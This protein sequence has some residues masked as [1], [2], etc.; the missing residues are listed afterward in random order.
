MKKGLMM[1]GI[2]TMMLASCTN[3]DVLNVS[4]SRAIGFNGTGIDNI[5]KAGDIT[6]SNFAHFYVYGGYGETAIFDKTEVSYNDGK[7]GYTPTKY[8]ANGTWKFAGY[9]GGNGV[10][11]TWSYAN[12]LTLEVNSNASHQSDVVYAASLDITVEDATTYNTPVALTFKHLLSKIQFKF[13]KDAQSLGGV[14]V[15]L[16]NFTVSG[17]TTN[18]K[19]E[20]G[21]QKA[22]TSAETGSYS[23]FSSAEE[24]VA[25]TGL[26]TDAFYVIPQTVGTFTITAN[27]V[28]T[29]A[30]GTEVH[31]GQIK[32]TVPTT[33]ITAW[34]AQNYY[35]YTATVA[36]SNIKDPENPDQEPKPIE[37]TGTT[38][39]DWNTPA[40]EDDVTLN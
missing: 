4:D 39:K 32:A 20:A 25:N 8:W 31:S 5:T 34:T 15:E 40:Q 9:E 16:S 13:L 35:I 36:M 38:A 30:A 24:I 7:W 37:F 23:D 21:E 27:A 17:I 29:D 2:A 33:D 19:W 6:S 1:L 22:A 18:A 11:P 26:S 12:G 28:V 10:T 14:T 3:E